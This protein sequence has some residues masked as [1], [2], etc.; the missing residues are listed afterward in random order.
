[1]KN[2]PSCKKEK[3]L[4]HEFWQRNASRGDG[5]DWQ[6]KECRK[7]RVN[8]VSQKLR[9][10]R[11]YEKDKKKCQAREIARNHYWQ[12]KFYCAAMTCDEEAKHLHHVDYD[13][14]L[15]IVP[16]CEKHHRG[17]HE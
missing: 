3:E 9:D 2:C 1:M 12:D 11:R 5:F 15:A 6:C 14:P 10:Q 4:S 8:K 17:I 16:L 7:L 13:E